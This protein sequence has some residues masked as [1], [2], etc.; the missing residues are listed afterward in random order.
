M[1]HGICT[2]ELASGGSVLA[3][4]VKSSHGI[5]ENTE[6]TCVIRNSKLAGS[7]TGVGVKVAMFNGLDETDVL[8][9]LASEHDSEH[10]SL[11]MIVEN[12]LIGL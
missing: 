11:D 1:S 12:V 9:E 8:A 6:I 4:L 10:L 2:N 3:A 5:L 7:L